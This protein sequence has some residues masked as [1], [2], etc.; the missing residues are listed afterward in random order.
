MTRDL[1]IVS[2]AFFWSMTSLSIAQDTTSTTSTTAAPASKTESSID[3][4]SDRMEVSDQNKTSIF[5]GK[6]VA[7]R[8]DMTL[9][10]DRLV[11]NY[12]D[13]KQPDGSS[14]NEVSD[15]NASG[16]VVIITNRQK[17]TGET[18]KLNYNTND[19]VVSGNVTVTQG[20]TVLR[21]PKLEANLNTN[22]MVMTG[23]RV[24]GSFVPK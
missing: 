6:V 13:T 4:E 8:P 3:V 20:A 22:Q 17:V 21:G 9:N 10:A 23:G 19:L 11:V 2:A 18:A 5:S 14:K 24:R 1:A 12:V 16:H 15:F 7:K